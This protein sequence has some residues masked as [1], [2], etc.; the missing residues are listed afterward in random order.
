MSTHRDFYSVLG[1]SRTAG[2]D[3]IKRAYRK[4]AKQYHPDRNPDNPEAERRFKE[5]QQAYNVLSDAEKR[6]DYDRFGE[7]GVGRF[8]T[9]PRG[10]RVY[11]WGDQ[12]AINIDD[13]EELF[14]AFGGGGP[15][16]SVFDQFFG[17]RGGAGAASAGAPRATAPRR[18]EDVEKPI[19]L[20]LDQVVHG[21]VVDVQL[22]SRRGGR[23][24]KLE[25]KIPPGVEDGQK[26]R[27]PGRGHA[28]AHG[29]PPGDFLLVCSI[30]PHTY[31]RRAG[32]DVLLDVPVSPVEA[33]LG[34]KVE[35]P[36]VD[37]FVT[38]SIPP[39]TASGAR[40]RLKGRGLPRRNSDERGDQLVVI[41]IAPPKELSEE[42]RRLYEQLGAEE[43]DDPRSTCPWQKE[44]AHRA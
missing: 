6:A 25:V 1:V 36:T 29:G 38:V 26:I 19:S 42:L 23:R 2:D 11:Q 21:A 34:K 9:D 13:L 4:L 27:L 24:E 8:S 10:Q 16:A 28:G 7:V 33:T 5:V 40:L 18:G 44:S 20:S 41:S 14:S 31:F 15:R 3:E 43:T 37:G 35:V 32:A 30:K 17:R 22:E 39:G 12:S